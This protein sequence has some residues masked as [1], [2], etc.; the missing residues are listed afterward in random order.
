MAPM[1]RPHAIG[2]L[3][4]LTAGAALVREHIAGEFR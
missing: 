3:G 1:S 4:A 2:K